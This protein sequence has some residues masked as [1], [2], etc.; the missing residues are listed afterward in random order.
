MYQDAIWASQERLA[1]PAY[2]TTTQ[3]FVTASLQGWIYCRDNAQECADIITA[4]GSKLGASHQL[5]MMNEVNKLIW[6]S[7]AGVG[8]I[9]PELWAQTVSVATSTKNLEGATVITAEPAAEAYTNTYAEA[10]NAELTAGGLNTTGDAFAPI[11]VTLN[12][13]GS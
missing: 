8:I 6:P 3:K 9:V 11:A 12:E 10:A 4:N 1:D 2:Q 13:G 5:W 7:P